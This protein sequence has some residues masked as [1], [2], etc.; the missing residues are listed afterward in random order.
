MTQRNYYKILGVEKT[1]TAWEIKKRYRELAKKHHPDVNN[2]SKKAENN[3]KILSTAY[4]ILSDKKK[5]SEYDRQRSRTQRTQ[6]RP[7]GSTGWAPPG[8]GFGY[9]ESRTRYQEDFNR[10]PHPQEQE[11]DPN[12]PTRGFDLQFMIDLPLIT[13]ALGGTIP[14]TYEKYVQ[15]PDCAGTDARESAE[16]ATCK[17][18]RLVV[19]WV[20]LN[21][22]IPPGVADQY[23][24]RFQNEGAEGR[25]GGPPG[26]LFLK[27]CTQPHPAFKRDKN[28]IYAEIFISQE[29]ADQGGP[30][31]VKTLNSVKTIQVEEGTLTGEEVRIPNEGAAIL[32]GKKRG[33]FIVKFMI[34]NNG[35]P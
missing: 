22:T 21:V 1:A 10:R 6:S 26:D 11:Y 28:D 29:L 16:C 34:D 30:L 7:G 5:R 17:G 12:L 8:S 33:D 35:S 23:T 15:C 31:E 32:W 9:Q 14:Y 20:T 13:V 4:Q 24:L 27:V 2:G 3:F 18:K 19:Q 25:N